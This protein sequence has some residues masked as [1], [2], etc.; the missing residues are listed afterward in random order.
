MNSVFYVAAF[1]IGGCFLVNFVCFVAI[2][3]KQGWAAVVWAVSIKIAF[4]AIA[5]ASA[6]VI[7]QFWGW[8]SIILI[9]ITVPISPIIAIIAIVLSYT[10]ELFDVSF[11]L[12]DVSF[13]AV[14]SALLL[15]CCSVPNKFTIA[16]LLAWLLLW[17]ILLNWLY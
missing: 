13:K 7:I 9:V 4:L 11:Y 2:F 3:F 1:I 16:T 12:F 5:L 15:W 10:R 14:S 17:T 6:T 8:W